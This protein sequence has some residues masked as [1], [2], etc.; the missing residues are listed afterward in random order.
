MNKLESDKGWEELH[1]RIEQLHA[2]YFRED[3]HKT[4]FNSNSNQGLS[5]AVVGC[6]EE[7]RSGC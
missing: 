3:W 6:S 1:K 2:K 4:H 5:L 7:L